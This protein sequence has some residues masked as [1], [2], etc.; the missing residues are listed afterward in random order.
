MD[1]DGRLDLSAE[2]FEEKIK[3]LTDATHLCVAYSGGI[4]SHVLLDLTV[5]TFRPQT[6]YQ[7]TALHIHHGIS[8][9]ADQWVKH[10][11]QV[12]ALLQVPLTVRWVNGKVTDGRSPE[13]V[14]REARFAAFAEFLQE[15]KCLLLAHHEADQAETILLRLFRGSGPLGLRGIPETALLAKGKILRPLLTVS[16]EAITQYAHANYLQW[17]EDESNRDNRFDRNFLRQQILPLLTTRWPRV[18]RSINRTGALCFE[19]ALAMQ[20]LAANDLQ[21][22]QGNKAEILSIAQLLKLE[23]LRRREVLRYWLQTLGCAFPSLD[24]ME[25]IDREILKARPDARPR[26]KIGSYEI[27]R[28]RDELSVHWL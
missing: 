8:Q 26:L 20:T 24:H 22:L 21:S 6:N 12:C 15:D 7:V 17:V 10:C 27:R 23:P 13:E 3:S 2:K 11:E 19:T 1:S 28:V 16:K 25:R 5:K 18:I 9:A 4:D 14:A